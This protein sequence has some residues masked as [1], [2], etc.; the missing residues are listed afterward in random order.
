MTREEMQRYL[1]QAARRGETETEALLH[2]AEIIGIQY[3][4]AEQNQAEQNQA[5]QN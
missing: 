1:D 4:A 3:H 5:E 2:L